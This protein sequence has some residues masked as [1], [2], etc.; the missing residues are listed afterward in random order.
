MLLCDFGGEKKGGIG[1]REFIWPCFKK[2]RSTFCQVV[3]ENKG[4]CKL[5]C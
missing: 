3:S 2:D 1:G 4:M 5:G